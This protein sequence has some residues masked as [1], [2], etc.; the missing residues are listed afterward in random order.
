[1]DNG[2]NLQTLN[3]KC[4]YRE[5]NPWHPVLKSLVQQKAI[6]MIC[7]YFFTILM[8]EDRFKYNK[9]DVIMRWY[10]KSVLYMKH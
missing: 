9:V 3:I 10:I 4:T 7:I 1:M 5:S 2:L 8:V 6:F